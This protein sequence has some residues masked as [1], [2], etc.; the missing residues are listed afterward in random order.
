MSFFDGK[1]EIVRPIATGAYFDAYEAVDTALGRPVFLKMSRVS[2][3]P[4]VAAV[5]E[6][7]VRQ[8]RVL[9]RAII[10]GMPAIH[11]FGRDSGRWCL[12]TQ[13]V[14]GQSL[15]TLLDEKAGA[16]GDPA[17]FILSVLER[18]L[19]ILADMHAG[20]L[21]HADVS[22][23]NILVD[24][25]ARSLNVYLV[26][27]APAVDLPDPNDPARRLIFGNPNFWAPEVQAGR[28]STASADLYALGKVI[29]H[30]AQRLKVAP[31]DLVRRLTALQPSDRPASAQEALAILRADR[32]LAP[33]PMAFAARAP[34]QDVAPP[35][36]LSWTGPTVLSSPLAQD[37]TRLAG[38]PAPPDA[39]NEAT[40]LMPVPGGPAGPTPEDVPAS[41]RAW[42]DATTLASPESEAPTRVVSAP[43]PAPAPPRGTW[44]EASALMSVPVPRPATDSA[45]AKAD[46]SVV[47]P[48]LIEAGRN[49]VV[50]VWV[51]PSGERDAMIEQATRN[52]RMAERSGRSHLNIDRDT[53]ITVVLKLP[54]FEVPDAIETM[55]WNGDIRNVGFIV[56]APASLPPG[57]Y[58]G[59]AKLLQGQIP[60]ASIMFDL[61]IVSPQ[62]RREAPPTPLSAHVH[63]IARAFASYASPDR[64][65]VLR[66]V[67]G[68]QAAGTQVF[69]DIINLRTGQDWEKALSHEIDASDGFF[70]FWSRHAAES[71]WVERE[72][73]YALQRRGLDFINPLP[74]E[75]P[76]LVKPPAELKSKHFN[77]ML[78]AFIKAEEVL[79]KGPG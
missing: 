12:V 21:V 68:I 19:F 14:A 39:W 3:E 69:L 25:N 29:G 31:P 26:D 33:A 45:P 41:S 62:G 20:G 78:L 54:D 64:A 13:W 53:L 48:N 17:G 63:R 38:V 2:N 22:P 71:E 10:Q 52:G 24:P 28:P 55:G 32:D 8:W 15:R 27:P 46:F 40:V 44:S 61:E 43:A 70:L 16:V 9:A 42:T 50:E 47:A 36:S 18:C 1:I 4:S 11:T 7:H 77:D 74:L 59:A 60:F 34:D 30:A 58:P 76:R 66:R 5:I 79:H 73:R 67:Q 6:A 72:W 37:A 49:F 75:D 51:A 56:K 57:V 23:G 65:E 35:G